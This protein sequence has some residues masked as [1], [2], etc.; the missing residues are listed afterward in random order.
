LQRDA[1]ERGADHAG[2][3]ESR[4]AERPEVPV[5]TSE[6]IDAD[7]N[8]LRRTRG[9][10]RS[11]RDDETPIGC[12]SHAL[13]EIP[14][15]HDVDGQFP[16]IS[17]SGVE[18]ASLVEAC[19]REVFGSIRLERDSREHDLAVRLLHDGIREVLEPE[20]VRRGHTIDTKC[21]IRSAVLEQPRDG[22]VVACI[23]G[24]N[25]LAVRLL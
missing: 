21:R 18:R 22:E 4:N 12:E 1:T 9:V 13:R 7:Q 3:F 16:G 6:L 10:R 5:E 17:E 20:E 24:Q 2:K 25:Q 15:F 11:A 14:V 23:A 19:D 8:C